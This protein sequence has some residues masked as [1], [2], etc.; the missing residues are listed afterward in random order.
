MILLPG[1]FLFLCLTS[2]PLDLWPRALALPC[3]RVNLGS[4]AC[5]LTPTHFCQWK[6]FT[7]SLFSPKPH[8]HRSA[9]SWSAAA[10][11]HSY[12]AVEDGVIDLSDAA[13]CYCSI[14]Q[15]FSSVVSASV[16]D[17][18]RSILCMDGLE[19]RTNS[20]MWPWSDGSPAVS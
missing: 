3:S 6:T 15:M 5:C 11:H 10:L 17:W 20:H 19:T 18:T 16:K 2:L 9:D 8:Q 4:A 14:S 12:T 13:K 7:E 1:Q